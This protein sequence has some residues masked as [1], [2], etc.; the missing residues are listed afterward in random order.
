MSKAVKVKFV[1]MGLVV[2][3][4]MFMAP[5]PSE[6]QSY[7]VQKGD[8]LWKIAQSFQTTIPKIMELNNIQNA[9]IYPGNTLQIPSSKPSKSNPVLSTANGNIA[10]NNTYG[11]YTVQEGDSLWLIAQK[12]GIQ[13]SDL[14][15]VNQ[16][17]NELIYPGQVLS[18]NRVKQNPAKTE[19]SSSSRGSSTEI[20][21]IAKRFLGVPYV[22]GGSSPK[23]FDCSG[24][25]QY[26]YSLHG[27]NIP[28]TAADQASTAQK[29]KTP[30]SGDLVC[31]ADKNGYIFHVGIYI[32]NNSFIHA[33]NKQGVVISSLSDN[34]YRSRFA[35]A[36]H[37]L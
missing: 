19:H 30:A 36:R 29:V 22:Y 37:V 7:V 9:L 13:V 33:N 11:R 1:V 16:L 18:I 12:H 31:F 4:W 27:K 28:R 15:E 25:V 2:S 23:G 8:S 21:D 20:V 3:L 32:G 26:V 35:G 17:A 14:M 6:A 10:N 5:T 34:W 24:F